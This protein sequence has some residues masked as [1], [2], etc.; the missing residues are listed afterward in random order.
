MPSSDDT[1]RQARM[2]L[3]A[4]L[5]SI[6][7][8]MAALTRK[9]DAVQAA[10]DALADGAARPKAKAAK[11]ADSRPTAQKAKHNTRA[12][13]C[14]LVHAPTDLT[15]DFDTLGQCETFCGLAP[16]SLS[17]RLRA[18]KDGVLRIADGVTVA[19]ID[20]ACDANRVE[21]RFADFSYTNDENGITYS[22][23]VVAAAELGCTPI[24]LHEM[25]CQEAKAA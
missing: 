4:L 14:R 23:I 5:A 13:A 2:A 22:D 18:T 6:D 8:E 17:P 11:K 12:R 19:A 20:K 3:R 16:K 15:V 1:T 21:N 24:A 9:R 10:L 25:E 7:D